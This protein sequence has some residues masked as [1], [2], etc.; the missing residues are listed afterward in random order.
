MKI[1]PTLAGF[2]GG[3]LSLIFLAAF[4]YTID[5]GRDHCFEYDQYIL[6][7]TECMMD[8]RCY[9]RVEDRL[10]YQLAKRRYA[11]YCVQGSGKMKETRA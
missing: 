6:A 5:E 8:Y 3:T 10:E 7:Y 9:F 2:I 11:M 1:S 4:I